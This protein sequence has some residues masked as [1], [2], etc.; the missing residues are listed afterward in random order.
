VKLATAYDDYVEFLDMVP[1]ATAEETEQER[2][3]YKT[4]ASLKCKFAPHSQDMDIRTGTIY[5]VTRVSAVT[6]N[7]FPLRILDGG[8]VFVHSIAEFHVWLDDQAGKVQQ[9]VTEFKKVIPIPSNMPR[10]DPEELIHDWETGVD[11][12]MSES[13]T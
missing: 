9:R 7:M 8:I 10:I 12:L 11:D 4:L 3:F 2:E 6:P 1:A 5:E 13:N